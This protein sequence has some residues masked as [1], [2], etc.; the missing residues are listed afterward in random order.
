MKSSLS[1]FAAALALTLAAAAQSQAD[2]F[3]YSY[4]WK[5]SVGPIL[6]PNGGVLMT[7]ND[8]GTAN[9]GIETAAVNVA[10]FSSASNT[11]PSPLPVIPPSFF[12]GHPYN[13]TL[14]VTLGDG[15]AGDPTA[16]ITFRG[17]LGGTLSHDS[18]NLDNSITGVADGT[19]DH[20]N[21][22]FG[23]IDVDGTQ[24]TVSYSGF[25][26]PTLANPGAISF[27]IGFSP[28]VSGIPRHRNH[29]AWY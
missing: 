28:E 19:G 6:A 25:T 20:N 10:W 13:Y 7:S 24:F 26:N 14:A 11:N 15:V 17:F 9:V 2:P 16:T 3:Q 5:L 1:L 18:A 27:H 12:P 29:R 8:S 22:T 4:D 23:V 21:Q